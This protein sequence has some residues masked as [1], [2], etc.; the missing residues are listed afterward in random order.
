MTFQ[1]AFLRFLK[2]AITLFLPYT[3]IFNPVTPFVRVFTP[4]ET[5]H[6]A[7]FHVL[8]L[9]KLVIK[10]SFDAF[11]S[12]NYLLRSFFRLLRRPGLFLL[13]NGSY[14]L[15]YKSVV[16]C[17]STC[18]LTLINEAQNAFEHSREFVINVIN[19]KHQWILKQPSFLFCLVV[20][21][22]SCT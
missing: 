1:N 13:N 4:F 14:R 5:R 19:R 8:R 20:L 12:Q 21:I 22:T 2:R 7:S 9:L 11:F 16:W 10:L 15:S 3:C 18:V 6:N 17:R